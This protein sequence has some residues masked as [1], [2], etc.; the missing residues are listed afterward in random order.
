MI[1]G[2]VGEK[3]TE[4][5]PPRK[6]GFLGIRERSFVSGGLVCPPSRVPRFGVINALVLPPKPWRRRT[7]QERDLPTSC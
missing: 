2:G 7:N 3:L 1:V 5:E 4:V 6:A